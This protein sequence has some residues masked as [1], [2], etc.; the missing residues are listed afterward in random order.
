[1]QQ[2]LG[3]LAAWLHER[4]E[5]IFYIEDLQPEALTLRHWR[6]YTM[7]LAFLLA[8]LV[9]LF[10]GFGGRE[11]N[12]GIVWA[13]SAW[14][15]LMLIGKQKNETTNVLP[16]DRPMR[17]SLLIGSVVGVAESIRLSL[18]RS[19]DAP[20]LVLII[21]PLLEILLIGLPTLMV[22][23]FFAQFA[24]AL[25]QFINKYI[26]KEIA[27]PV[28][29]ALWIAF[30]ASIG[31]TPFYLAGMYLRPGLYTF[32]VLYQGSL[33]IA[34]NTLICSSLFVSVGRKIQPVERLRWSWPT[35]LLFGLLAIATYLGNKPTTA[36]ISA[37]IIAL[38][39]LTGITTI[40][41]RRSPNQGIWQ[42]VRYSGLGAGV[43]FVI[44]LFLWVV[45]LGATRIGISF[46]P[47]ISLLAA[48]RSGL[49]PCL[50]HALVRLM[51]WWEGVAAFN[52]A[53]FLEAM[54]SSSLL[55]RTGG[56]YIFI[57]R[58]LLEHFL[59]SPKGNET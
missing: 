8:L 37:S 7:T 16:W 36:I 19:Y 48:L 44:W 2:W 42:S 50:Q 14:L 47:A 54:V 28:T 3:W 40:E 56:G 46:L 45:K 9:G 30:S 5:T 49:I 4:N 25:H 32:A 58:L 31:I 26:S 1:M 15:T 6:W 24:N 55:Y 23:L 11:P 39:G 13:A 51:L 21:A 59:H 12:T 20:L 27:F 35:T 17:N 57:H 34:T 41:T 10:V 53:H 38:G 33:A 29:V 43:G 18:T 22:S 52:Y